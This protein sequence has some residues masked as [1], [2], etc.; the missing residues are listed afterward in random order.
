MSQID[1]RQALRLFAG[2][3]AAGFLAACGNDD[4]ADA[5]DGN[6]LVSDEPIKIGL[7]VPQTAGYKSVGD[8]LTRGFNLYLEMNDQRLGGHHVQLA[9][10]DEGETVE[11]GKAA[12]DGLLK[13]GVL[14][15][16]G[17]V[18]STVMLGIRDTVE[19]ARIPL[20]GSCASPSALQS[21]VYIWRTSYVNNE[22]GAALGRY[23]GEEVDGKVGII[24]P[25]YEAGRDAVDGFRTAFGVSDSRLSAGPVWT[26]YVT[27][28]TK[29]FFKSEIDKV[30]Q[31]NPK[32]IYC[33]YS[34]QAAV[35]FLRQLH[36]DGYRGAVYAPGF[37][38]EGEVLGE[39]KRNEA[40]DVFTALNYSPDLNNAAN[41]E[42]ATLFR[43]KYGATPTTYAVA[44]YDAAQVIDKAVRLAG[45]D[46]TPQAV[47]LALGKIGLIDSP[48]GEWQFN[49]TRTPQQKWY[50]R[51]VRRDG[52]VL[53]N[54]V[55]SELET[56]G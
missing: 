6:R 31:G 22:A 45:A 34:G 7:I 27:E 25:N 50:L 2:L 33:F 40:N 52:P 1:R 13:Q 23:V 44:S 36:D 30:R 10:A 35:E 37:L 56:L 41:R 29:T 15:L 53:S 19:Q 9:V 26:E 17:V 12:L 11:S 3:G 48:R 42:F 32:A 49:Q 46:P 39:L 47:N 5:A 43:N 21:V 24:A 38:T 16:T 28:P 20:I 14:A 55:I 18:S 54:V 51:Q 8:E 4:S